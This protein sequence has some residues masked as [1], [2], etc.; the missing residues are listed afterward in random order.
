MT[1]F[2][3]GLFIGAIGVIVIAYF[4]WKNNKKKF[5]AALAEAV[6][7]PGTPQEKI[8]KILEILKA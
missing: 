8:K 3:F 2:I 5:I 1:S 4:I 6:E 7:G